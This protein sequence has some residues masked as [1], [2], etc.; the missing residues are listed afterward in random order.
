VKVHRLKA[1]GSFGGEQVLSPLPFLV[2]RP[3][4]VDAFFPLNKRLHAASNRE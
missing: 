1:F 3:H 4:C 2:L